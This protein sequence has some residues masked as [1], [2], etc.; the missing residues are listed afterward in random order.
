MSLR[1]SRTGAEVGGAVGT[2]VIAV[3]V[4]LMSY[5]L[6]VNEYVSVFGDEMAGAHD[7]DGPAA[8]GTLAAAGIVLGVLG[9]VWS[10]S[11]LRR[12]H[13]RAARVT[14]GVA[15]IV[16]LVA[17]ARIVRT[18]PEIRRNAAPDSPCQ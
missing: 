16:V 3:L 11:V 13:T 9:V 15:I 5:L 10:G 14:A 4:T 12:S 2:V 7:C 1:R 8:V 6:S 18:I 17:S